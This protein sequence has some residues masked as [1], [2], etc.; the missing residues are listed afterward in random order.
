MSEQT[1][2][3]IQDEAKKLKDLALYSTN[4]SLVAK[5]IAANDQ[6]VQKLLESKINE[7]DVF[8]GIVCVSSCAGCQEIDVI[9]RFTS[10]EE[11]V[12]FLDPSFAAEVSLKKRKVVSIQDPYIEDS[13]LSGDQSIAGTELGPDAPLPLFM[14]SSVEEVYMG[15]DEMDEYVQMEDDFAQKEMLSSISSPMIL[16]TSSSRRYCIGT[17]NSTASRSPVG[18]TT[19]PT[20]N[21]PMRDTTRADMAPDTKQDYKQDCSTRR[22]QDD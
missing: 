15:L 5:S 4:S 1:L 9:F 6:E 22:V 10:R 13:S 21:P 7:G 12:S 19:N 17:V 18:R 14:P 16:S 11:A 8:S 3:R 20:P 2:K